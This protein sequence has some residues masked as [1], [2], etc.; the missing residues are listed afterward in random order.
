MII[1]MAAGQLLAAFLFIAYVCFCYLS[2]SLSGGQGSLQNIADV[3]F[4][5]QVQQEL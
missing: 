3:Y 5:A 4:N 1:M 2:L